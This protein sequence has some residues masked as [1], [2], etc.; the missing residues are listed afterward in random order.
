MR[1]VEDWP[2]DDDRIDAAVLALL[3]L[4]AFA[5]GHG[6]VRAWKT[7]SWDALDRLHQRGLIGNP[8]STAKSVVLT[9]EGQAAASDAADRLFGR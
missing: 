7:M 4:N 3:H 1:V 9:E 5:E 6:M 2:Y 8:K